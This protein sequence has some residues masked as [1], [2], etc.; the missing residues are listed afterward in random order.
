MCIVR[1]PSIT[2]ESHCC[3]ICSFY[4]LVL[5]LY[6]PLLIWTC[7]LYGEY[8]IKV[9]IIIIIIMSLTTSEPHGKITFIHSYIHSFIHSFIHSSLDRDGRWLHGRMFQP[10]SFSNESCPELS[11]VGPLKLT[12]WQRYTPI[13]LYPTAPLYNVIII[14]D[15]ILRQKRNFKYEK[16]LIQRRCHVSSLA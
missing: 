16:E 13:T 11:Q 8:E 2:S 14:Y 12:F 6:W 4:T 15:T 5:F 7:N 1:G 3:I 10:L 9:Y